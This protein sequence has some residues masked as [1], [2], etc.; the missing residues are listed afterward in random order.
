MME[1]V[2]CQ[3]WNIGMKPSDSEYKRLYLQ[4][5]QRGHFKKTAEKDMKSQYKAFPE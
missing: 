3:I 2:L 4:R 5:D 1:Y